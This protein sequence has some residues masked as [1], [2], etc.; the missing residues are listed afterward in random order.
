METTGFGWPGC[1]SMTPIMVF[2]VYKY[3]VFSPKRNS[4]GQSIFE[5]EARG[6]EA[7]LRIRSYECGYLRRVRGR[8][9]LRT[10]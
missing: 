5:R 8:K 4:P 3:S 7:S 10:L 1:A 2:R 9:D 6:K